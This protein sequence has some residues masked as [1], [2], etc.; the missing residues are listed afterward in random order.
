MNDITDNLIFGN[1]YHI[2]R[3]VFD[4]EKINIILL[5]NADKF[6]V[7][8]QQ[9]STRYF[10][11]LGYDEYLDNFC[12]N[13][14]FLDIVE[15]SI[16]GLTICSDYEVNILH[17]GSKSSGCHI[18]YPYTIINKYFSVQPVYCLTVLCMLDDFTETNG[19]TKI[20]PHS[21]L[22]CQWP[23]VEEFE[24]NAIKVLGRAG[25]IIIFNG[26]L[27]HDTSPNLSD[28]D[29]KALLLQYSP[30]FVKPLQDITKKLSQEYKDN[31]N[32]K[33]KQLIGLDNYKYFF[34]MI[35]EK[36]GQEYT[37]G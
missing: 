37:K 11:L 13:S 29:R 34:K 25:D 21:Q 12:F 22:I 14:I 2:L 1:G 4:A 10:H 28:K 17:P 36:Q 35:K 3:Q 24:Q 18:D 27:W 20:Y 7:F 31:L 23:K 32:P 30:S 26:A 9:Y 5:N 16:D 19:A 33:L 6:S 8:K 15:N